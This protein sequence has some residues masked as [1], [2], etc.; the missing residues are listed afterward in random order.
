MHLLVCSDRCTFMSLN[1]SSIVR[2]HYI[3]IFIFMLCDWC[4]NVLYM[5]SYWRLSEYDHLS[6]KQL[7]YLKFMRN[8]QFYC[9]Y[10]FVCENDSKHFLLELY[11]IN[12]NTCTVN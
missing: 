1:H 8:M 6:L 10:M 3:S 7:G 4:S 11:I 2:R 9:V 5:P 12:S